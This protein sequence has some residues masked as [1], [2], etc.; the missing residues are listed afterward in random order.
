MRAIVLDA[1]GGVENFREADVPAPQPQAE[2]VRIRTRAAG[3]NPVDYKIRRNGSPWEL[4]LILGHEAAGVVD[5]VGSRV[6]SFAKGDEVYAFL[7]VPRSNGSYAEFSCIDEWFVAPKPT[8]L[9]F[10]QAAALPVAGLTA[11]ECIFRKVQ[12]EPGTPVFVAGGS[13]GVGSIL[14]QLLQYLDAHPILTTAGGEES[15][16]YLTDKFRIESRHILRYAGKS[17]E[18]MR[19]R[20]VEMNDGKLVPV[21]Y[22]LVGG[23][24]KRLCVAVSALEGHIVSIVEEPDDFTIGADGKRGDLFLHSASYHTEFVLARSLMTGRAGW[25]LYREELDTLARLIG[26]EQLKCPPV[27]TLGDLS[28]ETIRQGHQQLEAGHTKGKLVVTVP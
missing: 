5:A 19:D 4:P 10:E 16:S 15:A 28:L 17:L 14:I 8:G 7:G 27:T 26:D 24:M 11:Y 2:Q 22:D 13:G 23:Q 18:E 6:R 3:L 25:E 21:A 1:F 20:V 12:P 9:N